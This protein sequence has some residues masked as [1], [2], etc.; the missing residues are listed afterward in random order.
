MDIIELEDT[1]HARIA[2]LA[3]RVLRTGGVVISPAD[4]A[5]SI[6]G[7]AGSESAL[8]RMMNLKRQPE[9]KSL[10]VFVKDVATAGRYAYISDA[11]AR[12]LTHIWPGPITVLLHHK[13]K[14]PPVLTGGLDTIGLRMPCDPFLI[15]LLRRFDAPIAQTPACISGKPAAQDIEQIKEYFEDANIRPDLVI[16]GGMLRGGTS[17]LLDLTGNRPMVLRTGVLTREQLDDLMASML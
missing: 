12:F 17:T 7:S 10:P 14:L 15:A 11:K 3:E 1:N 5:Y 13:E 6:L 2:I 4:T 9:E 16:D 8:G